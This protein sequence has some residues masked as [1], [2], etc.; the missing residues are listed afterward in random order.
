MN[1][2]SKLN[3]KD[4]EKLCNSFGNSCKV[5]EESLDEKEEM[6]PEISSRDIENYND[7]VDKSDYELLNNK[8]ILNLSTN[9]WGKCISVSNQY[10]QRNLLRYNKNFKVYSTDDSD[11][12]SEF[13][14]KNNSPGFDLVIFDKIK[15]KYY[16]I[17]S[18]LR[19]IEGKTNYSRR[20]NF[21]T[22]RRNSSKNENKNK[23]GHI[24][25]SLDE[26]DYVCVSLIPINT[27]NSR[28]DINLWGFSLI[29]VKELKDGENDFCMTNIPAK[30]LFNYKID[31]FTNIIF[32]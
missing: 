18:K 1:V 3:K 15:N 30:T 8:R 5:L 16:R 9:D 11:C 4:E 25:Y 31:N 28:N 19:Q 7:Y 6:L 13:K 29:P 14:I 27:D 21:E 26:F 32:E 22:T 20:V 10:I 2:S 12:P 24:A 23:T 17:Q